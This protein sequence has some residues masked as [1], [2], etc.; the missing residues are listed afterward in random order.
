MDK[1]II[2]KDTN[3]NYN[4]LLC[5]YKIIG[6]PKKTALIKR[7][8]LTKCEHCKKLM[9]LVDEGTIKVI[10]PDLSEDPKVKY[11][12]NRGHTYSTA[13]NKL[14]REEGRDALMF[15]KE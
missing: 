10:I 3:K 13:V 8:H 7:L 5:G 14:L 1:P 2:F 11:Y 4:E 12:M 9:A 15:L 6:N